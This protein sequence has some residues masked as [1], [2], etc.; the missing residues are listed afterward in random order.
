MLLDLLFHLYTVFTAS[1]VIIATLLAFIIFRAKNDSG[2]IQ[3]F[4]G[5]IL[6]ALA[7]SVLFNS[8][9]HIYLSKLDSSISYIYE[10]FQ[11]II[12][13]LFYVYLQR[14]NKI[15]IKPRIILLHFM[16]FILSAC[17]LI[18][19]LSVRQNSW[20]SHR[21]ID[22]Y[23]NWIA[24]ISYLQL[25]FYLLLC[26]K[27]LKK[28]RY[29]LKQSCS[30]LEKISESWIEKSLYILLLGYSGV[31]IVYL[32][33]HS[34]YSLPIHKSL[35]FI[36]T[37]LIYFIVYK[38]LRRPEVFS[39]ILTLN[40]NVPVKQ[41]VKTKENKYQKSGLSQQDVI[42]IYERVQEHIIK[43]K[44]FIDPE[45][46]LP[47]LAEQ[48]NLSAHQLSQVIN[49][50]KDSNFYDFVNAYRIDE[51]K[52]QLCAPN[53]KNRSIITI[54]FD[55]GFNSKATFNRIFKSVT[56]Q[57]PSAYRKSN[58]VIGIDQ[59]NDEVTLL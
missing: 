17:Y 54:A 44:S 21:V 55:A 43:N 18:L 20:F 12:G 33:N 49:H 37:I 7:L 22:E 29:Q 53:S 32:S 24:F 26:H 57:T 13:P 3:N 39:G 42:N 31:S 56:K 52:K 23:S 36:Y 11:L 51:V 28:Y 6:I 14:L 9:L 4:I 27:Q 59:K 10:P 46:N 40:V 5:C 41:V 1:S 8:L 16:L 50:G 2:N 30:T 35:A 38:T 34:D 15:N 45:L 25:W 47:M 58:C 48:L 19:M